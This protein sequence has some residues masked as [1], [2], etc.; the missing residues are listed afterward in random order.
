MISIC[1]RLTALFCFFSLA[2]PVFGFA[3]AARHYKIEL[4]IQDSLSV[5]APEGTIVLTQSADGQTSVLVQRVGGLASDEGWSLINERR[6]SRVQLEVRV[7]NARVA[8]ERGPKFQIEVRTAL[9]P[10][11]LA[12]RKGTIRADNFAAP[13]Q[14]HVQT[15]D[16][17]INGGSGDVGVVHQDGSLNIKSHQGKLRAESFQGR[18]TVQDSSGSAEIEN[19]S[20]ETNVTRHEGGLQI[21]SLRGTS[22]IVGL[23]GRLQFWQGRGGLQVDDLTGALVGQSQ[24]GP[25][26]ASI[27]GE[28]E[29]KVTTG[30]APVVLTLRDSGA[31]LNLATQDGNIAAPNYLKVN[32]LGSQKTLRGRLKG[33]QHGVVEV[34]TDAGSIRLN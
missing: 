4:G 16:V 10:V 30:E 19:F 24:Q 27:L 29:V 14:V 17:Q 6:G 13:L 5:S 18:I 11:E 9:R 7:P 33:S 12:L 2:A 31:R 22:K 32:D 1:K 28:A 21:V 25:V 34:R 26:K 8:V 23:K 20:G 15:G 3:E